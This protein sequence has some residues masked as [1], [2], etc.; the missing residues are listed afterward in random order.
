MK[1]AYRTGMTILI[2]ALSSAAY[3]QTDAQSNL[4]SAN[5]KVSES[6]ARETALDSVG[7][8]VVG[9]GALSSQNGRLL[10]VFDVARPGASGIIEVYVDANT[11]RLVRRGL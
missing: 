6:Q 10:W 4:L 11:G 5:P 3:A 1:L 7:N 2:A 9:T 8:G